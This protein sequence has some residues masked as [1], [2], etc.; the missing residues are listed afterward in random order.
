M[1]HLLQCLQCRELPGS[2]KEQTSEVRT[3]LGRSPSDEYGRVELDA[4][5]E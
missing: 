5:G 1:P 3:Q 2:A 4:L